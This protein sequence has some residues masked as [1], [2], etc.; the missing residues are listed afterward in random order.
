MQGAAVPEAAQSSVPVTSASEDASDSVCM[1]SDTFSKAP[2][3]SPA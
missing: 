1:H 2:R 3:Y